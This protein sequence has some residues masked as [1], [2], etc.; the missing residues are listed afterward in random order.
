MP[1]SVVS[2]PT[3]GSALP[4][5]LDPTAWQAMVLAHQ[6]L[7]DQLTDAHRSRN[8]HHLAH[9]VQDF[10]FT[11]YRQRPAQLR[12]WHPGA[13]VELVAASTDFADRRFYRQDQQTGN[14]V[15]D[16]SEF[17]AERRETLD[18][19]RRLLPATA[20]ATPQFGCFGLHE[21]AM[22]HQLHS[23][24]RR[25]P[26]WPLRLTPAQTDAV[27]E[28]HQ[29][30]C[31]HF[32]AFR[33][34]TPTARPMNLLQ[35]SVGSRVEMEQPGCLHATMDLYK[36]AYKLVPLLSSDL[37]VEC[38]LL[39]REVREWDMRASPYDLRELGYQPVQIETPEGKAAYVA[40][41]REFATLGQTLRAKLI[42]SVDSALSTLEV[43]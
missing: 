14:T 29:I 28:S 12:Q 15:V 38:F 18:L 23:D 6:E 30:K 13:G 1:E 35:P 16:L 7:V 20:S 37:V 33:F 26:S 39:A 25:H 10:L 4:R 9:P 11:Y 42:A 36:W 5:V 31:S 41:Q 21:W 17:V 3:V 27:V 19:V 34:F 22:V 24:T 43:E 40:R 32:D 8:R 2:E